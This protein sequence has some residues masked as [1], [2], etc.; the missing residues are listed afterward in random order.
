MRTTTREKGTGPVAEATYVGDGGTDV[1]ATTGN[2]KRDRDDAGRAAWVTGGGGG[3][4]DDQGDGEGSGDGECGGGADGGRG[5][6][7]EGRQTPT[8]SP[9]SAGVTREPHRR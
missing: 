1:D 4:D 7:G 9:R 3:G 6:R 8:A 2:R 5:D